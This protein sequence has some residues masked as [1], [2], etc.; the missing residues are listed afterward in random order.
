MIRVELLI[1]W[2]HLGDDSSRFK[3]VVF[4][5]L[6]S[7]EFGATLL[8]GGPGVRPLLAFLLPLPDL[9]SSPLAPGRQA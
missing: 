2:R 7:A 9:A 3:Y 8:D 5:S 6:S 4:C 1:R